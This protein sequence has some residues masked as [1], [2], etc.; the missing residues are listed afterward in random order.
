MNEIFKKRHSV[1]KFE[2]DMIPEKDLIEIIT[3]GTLAP[4]GKNVQNWHFVLISNPKLISG[5]ADIVRNKN[6]EISESTGDAQKGASF[7]KHVKYHT[8]FEH[9]P[10]LLL[11]Y[12]GPYAATGIDLLKSIEGEEERV[13]QLEIARPGIQNISAAMENILLAAADMGYGGV[14]MTGPNY[15]SMEIESLID[16]NKEG[17]HL[18]CMTPLGIPLFKDSPSPPRKPLE[19]VFTHIK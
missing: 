5:I 12:S 7:A 17:Y 16:F 19:E 2:S 3:A 4:S 8:V 11:V 13:R 6:K 18:A 1:R 9:A 10:H 15:A 14:W